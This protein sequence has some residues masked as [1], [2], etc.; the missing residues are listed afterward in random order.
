MQERHHNRKRYFDE[1]V[2]TTE[3]FVI[4]FIS[5]TMRIDSNTRVLEIGCGEGGNLQ[6]FL[7]RGCT[8]VGI[9]LSEGKINNAK[10][11]YEA[12]P[13]KEKIEF[14]AED[15]YKSEALGEFDLVFARDVL[16]H[17][18]G[19]EKFMHFVKKFLK[20]Q[21]KIF[22]GFPP[23]QNPFGGHQQMCRSK[24]LASMP[25]LH[26]LP[27]FAYRGVLKLF[28]EQ[29]G[30]INDLLEI[31]ETRITIERFQ[32]ILKHENYKIEKRCFYFINPNY[33]IKF[34]L[35]PRVVWGVI[36]KT[37]YVRNFMITTNYYIISV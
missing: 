1:Q 21:A 23:W 19:Q 30:R 14:I 6:P 32:R 33:E 4:P 28:K 37:P 13:K 25:F 35:K 29:E 34:G 22:L 31:K 9:D 17:I 20:P 10:A 24:V 36:A 5:E 16:E 7:D 3:K 8:C 18:H 26:L 12:H 11:Y 2:I 27:V 15:I